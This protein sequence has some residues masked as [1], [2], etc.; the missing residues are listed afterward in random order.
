M[1]KAEQTE[2]SRK[3]GRKSFRTSGK[4]A[5]VCFSACSTPCLC[6][7]TKGAQKRKAE[8]GSVPHVLA[9]DHCQSSLQSLRMVGDWVPKPQL[10]RHS[11][12]CSA[13]QL[14][15]CFCTT[16][17]WHQDSV[18][19]VT[20]C[21]A[22]F[23]SLLC[24][25]KY[26]ELRKRYIARWKSLAI[27]FLLL[28]WLGIKT[29]LYS[30]SCPAFHPSGPPSPS[31]QGCSQVCTRIWDCPDPGATPHPWPCST[32]SGSHSSG[33]KHWNHPHLVHWSCLR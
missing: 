4:L 23:H 33:F 31:P 7:Q 32:S 30:G 19:T 14:E 16:Q 1:G 21:L 6:G 5:G 26:T 12:F 18:L 11:N 25:A 2:T 29:S 3:C 20:A 13:K 22:A 17:L 8:D 24:A 10:C 9:A 15:T 28:L 27:W